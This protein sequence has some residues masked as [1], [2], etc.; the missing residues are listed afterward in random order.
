MFFVYLDNSPLSYACFAN[1]FSKLVTPLLSFSL[2][3]FDLGD[4][5]L[6]FVLNLNLS[7]ALF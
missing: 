6:F 4:F 2:K 7:H 1:I 3:S 5:V